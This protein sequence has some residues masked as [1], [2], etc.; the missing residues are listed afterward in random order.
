MTI[1]PT[2]FLQPVE[3]N[4]QEQ[5]GNTSK[6]TLE[7]QK[8]VRKKFLTLDIEERKRKGLEEAETTLFFKLFHIYNVTII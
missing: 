3:Q 7:D 5:R 4:G 6:G 8:R 2:T 1:V